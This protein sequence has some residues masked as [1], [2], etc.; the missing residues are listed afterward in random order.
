M[1]IGL[2]IVTPTLNAARWLPACLANVAEQGYESVEHIIVDGGS[3]DATLELAQTVSGVLV[4]DRPGTNQAQAINEG[5]RAARG[6]V[7]AWLNADDEYTPDTLRLVAQHFAARPEL[8]ALYGDCDVIDSGTRLLWRERPGPYDFQRLLRS[9]NY[10][11]Q[12]AVFVHRRV[13]ER[14]GYLDESFECGMDL[15]LWLRLKDCHV[16]YV[17][18]VLAR[19]RWYASSKTAINQF[20]CW[21]E[22]LRLVRR[23]G[24]GW[25]PQLAWKFAR[26]LLTLV[27][28]RAQLALKGA[29]T[30]EWLRVPRLDS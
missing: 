5:F 1:T 28:E 12:P 24:G 20:G 30:R 2:S 11:A 22:L 18:R 15:E 19:Y 27:R 7:L 29:P 10:L 4:L 25:T 13:F 3:R 9:G 16:E 21:R 14:S 6:D 8:D 26:M 23:H 17:P